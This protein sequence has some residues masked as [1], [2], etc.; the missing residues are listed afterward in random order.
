MPEIQK[1]EGLRA[2]LSRMAAEPAFGFQLPDGA[3]P[4]MAAAIFSE[5]KQPLAVICPNVAA[6]ERFAAEAAD[7]LPADRAVILPDWESYPFESVRPDVVAIGKRAE[8]IRRLA[9]GEPLLVCLAVGTLLQK[10]PPPAA[11][12]F[13]GIALAAEMEIDL[14]LLAESLVEIGYVRLPVVEGPGEFTVRGSV[15]DIFP[16]Q[17]SSPVR[18]DYF[19]DEIESI[20]TF[21]VA[22]QRSTGSLTDI[23]I[24]SS[25]EFRLDTKATERVMAAGGLLSGEEDGHRWL[26]IIHDLTSLSGYFPPQTLWVIDEAKSVY[27]EA[28]RFFD[29]QSRALSEGYAG[30]TR[31]SARSYYLT[32]EETWSLVAPRLE[33]ALVGTSAEY[34]S[35]DA[36]R[37]EEIAGRLDRLQARLNEFRATG[38]RAVLVLRDTGERD[39]VAELISEMGL[40]FDPSDLVVG[41][42]KNGYLLPE[43]RLAVFGYADIFPHHEVEAA[44]TARPKRRALIDFSDL[45]HGELLVHEIHGIA[46]FAGL[47]QKTVAGKTREYL[48]LDYAAGDR[49][50]LPT[51][52]IHR[53]SRYVGP[54]GVQPEITR[55]GSPDWL[56]T[57]RKI[58][59]SL[60]KLAVDLMALYAERVEHPG[61]AFAPDGQWQRELEAA[62]PYEATRDQMTAISE[63][64][65]DMEAAKPM[66][67][68]VCGDVGYGKT[69]VAIRAAF[70]AVLDGKQVMMLVPTTILAQQHYLTF[71]ERFAPYPVR[72]DMLSRFLSAGEQ[73]E[74]VAGVKAGGVDMVIG[75]HRL[76]QKDIKFKDLGLII[77]DEEHRF[78]VNAKEKLRLLRRSVDVMAL[79]ATPIPRTLQMSLGGVRDLSLIE[80]PPEGRHPVQTTITEFQPVV[81]HTAIQRELARGGQIFYVHNRVETIERAAAKV[82]TLVPEARIILGH[83]QMSESTLERVMLKF[84]SHEVDVLVC[85]T[86][87]ESGIDIPSANTMIIEN[88]DRLGLAQLYQLRGR[89]G[90]GGD[91]GYAYF[92]YEPGRVM[93]DTAVERLKTIGEFTELG[94]GFK[95]AL[96]DLQIRGAGNILGAEQHG[97]V[98]SVGFDLYSRMLR[99]ELDRIQGKTATVVPEV[100]IELPIN[101]YLPDSYIQDEN[102]RLEMYRAIAGAGSAQEIDDVRMELDDRFGPVPAPAAN[103][104]AVAG[105]RRPAAVAG[106]TA[107]TLQKGRLVIK[108]PD[109]ARIGQNNRFELNVKPMKGEVVVKVP[110]SQPDILK[111]VINFI[112]VI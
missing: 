15:V 20:K 110:P 98:V 71:M 104:L 58:R 90:R 4:A 69:E 82:Q 64:K 94:S 28:A 54:E 97:H 44:A 35:I 78:G 87:I 96:R 7:Y 33:M 80:T 10:V 14:H 106:I 29:A 112:N 85:T 103:L 57:T 88:A 77:V 105:L 101:A 63:V 61:H 36:G 74:V 13:N 25:R 108:S 3:R 24:G 32:P 22:S 48:L 42:T 65:A 38:W 16:S 84:L 92:T 86:I 95:V 26:P 55:L 83:G 50:Y 49:L 37:Q 99:Q 43:L 72:V 31:F 111:F 18:L 6:A 76:L 53:V 47:T 23:Y 75:T 56:R 89:V 93:T 5:R 107:I 79:S 34:V 30:D 17:A 62:F 51:D 91:R 45:A 9:G 11:R 8:V 70:K 73:K 52:Q 100:L 19:G 46:A 41:R 66:D 68:L 2:G 59:S 39:R 81:V 12:A 109:V 60:K 27:D 40:D 67:R 1:L 102:L 21:D